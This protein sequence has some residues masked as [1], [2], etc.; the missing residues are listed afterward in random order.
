MS[1]LACP[2]RDFPGPPSAAVDVPEAWLPVHAP[3]TF[4]A[5]KLIRSVVA[6]V[7]VRPWAPAPV[8]AERNP[9]T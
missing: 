4:F 1:T 6:S 2:S 9:V 5:A 7:R 8:E 3:G